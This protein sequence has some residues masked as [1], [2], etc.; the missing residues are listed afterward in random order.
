[1]NGKLIILGILMRS[2]DK[3]AIRKAELSQPL[4]TALQVALIDLLATWGVKPCAVVGH[5]SGEIAAA[6]AAGAISRKEAIIT[7]FYRGFVCRNLKVV[8]GMAAIGLGQKEVAPYLVPGVSIACENSTSSTTLSGDLDVLESVMGA[9]KKDHPNILVRR[10]EVE[11]AYHSR[12][13]FCRN[14]HTLLTRGIRAYATPWESLLR[15]DFIAFV[16]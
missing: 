13:L 3:S 14:P 4:C 15:L 8:G 10:L 12:E 2:E 6:Y 1:M 16:T 11:M 9:I 7:A 5:S